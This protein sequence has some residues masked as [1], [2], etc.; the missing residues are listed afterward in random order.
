[1][2]DRGHIKM[3]LENV[4]ASQEWRTLTNV[5]QLHSF[6]GL[7]NYYR[8]FIEGYSRKA[9]PLT[10]LLKKGV[11]WEWTDKCQEA[12]DELKIAM[13]KGSILTLPNIS[14]PFEVQTDALDFTLGWVLLQK[15]HP[16]EFESHKL[17]ET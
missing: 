3:D 14:K 15:G 17:S 16:L 4:R 11:T 10:E 9:V 7:A 1:M 8:R 6:F 5:K 13:M 12:F 2:V